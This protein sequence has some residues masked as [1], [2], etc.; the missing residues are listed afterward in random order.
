MS[1]R[2]ERVVPVF[3]HFLRHMD[4]GVTDKIYNGAVESLAQH[5]GPDAV[6][7]LK[8]ALHQGVWWAPFR[9]RRRRAAAAAALRMIGSP[10]ALDVLRAAS[11]RGPRGVR[12]IARAEMARVEV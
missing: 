9:T 2:D 11:T 6:D 3:S 7:A 10:P 1:I 8:F 4:A 5:G 12:T